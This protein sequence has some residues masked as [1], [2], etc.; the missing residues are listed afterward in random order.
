L[1]RRQ[2]ATE[3]YGFFTYTV[4]KESQRFRPIQLIEPSG[5]AEHWVRPR[6]ASTRLYFVGVGNVRPD[7]VTQLATQS[8]ETLGINVEQLPDVSFDRVT[9]DND[10]SQVVCG[11]T[12]RGDQAP[13]SSAGSRRRRPD[14]RLDRR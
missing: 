1:I 9:V 2:W 11:G 13:V 6:Q 4:V 5:F 7:L 14:H 8:R 3:W 10:R 12:R